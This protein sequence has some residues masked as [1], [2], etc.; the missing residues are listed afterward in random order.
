MRRAGLRGPAAESQPMTMQL[1]EA[2]R[3][4]RL[5]LP[6]LLMTASAA[7]WATTA[8]RPESGAH[9]VDEHGRTVVTSAARFEAVLA[10]GLPRVVSLPTADG[11]SGRFTIR[12]APVMEAE[13]AAR[14]PRIRTYRGAG[15]DDPTSL[16]RLDLT[17]LGFH[18]MVL[19]PSGTVL[20]DP[21]EARPLDAGRISLPGRVRA[22]S[23]LRCATP[24]RE[25]D[26][27]AR[28]VVVP[29]SRAVT[30]DLLRTYRIAIAATGEYTAFH[31][32]TVETGLAA[33]ITVLNRIAGI[34]ER[35]ASV[36]LILA[37][38]NDQIIY[39]DA[40]A[41]PYTNAD[42]R[43]MTVENQENL[44][45]VI[46]SGNYDIGHVFGT[47]PQGRGEGRVCEEGRKGRGV[48]G[49]PRPTAE[50]F[51]IQLVVHEIG[52]Q[53]DA[54]HTF[55]G[56]TR[57]CAGRRWGP[58]AWEPGS[59]STIMSYAGICGRENVAKLGDDY[60]HTGSVDEMLAWVS[61]GVG[62]GCG[63]ASAGDNSPP[64]ADAGKR[65]KI[66]VETP[67]ELSGS[68]GDPDGDALTFVWEQFD[69]GPPSPPMADDGLRPLFRS[70]PPAA[71]ATRIIPRT[72]DLLRRRSTVKEILPTT[73]RKL[74]FRLTV[75]DG[76]GGVAYDTVKL[77]VEDEAGPFRL[78]V[79]RARDAWRIGGEESVEWAVAETDRK[80]I[81]CRRVDLWLSSDG[82]KTFPILLLEGTPNDGFEMVAVPD[83]PTARA[84]VKV[85]CSTNIFF[86][87]SDGDFR[88]R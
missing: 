19:S 48:S 13:L 59:G 50:F 8:E 76:R 54:S 22:S 31:G 82:G 88:L 4:L 41:D 24:G 85:S 47:Y 16:A 79:P 52:H 9:P 2:T 60:F 37:N 75:R 36:R 55:N 80:P 33:V 86:A 28:S 70:Y 63:E 11:G 84:R 23:P 6:F 39:T 83:E 26:A 74:T 3:A 32:G 81:R 69:L 15:I 72:R 29:A 53:F 71:E 44:D 43:R 14:F 12:E 62:A 45:R 66:P 5:A 73:K 78:L 58:S 56:T 38:D 35:D 27:A 42:P 34:F 25:H 18:A 64:T 51:A 87:I 1:P 40:E 10:R 20:V 49:L 68:A 61:E 21:D 65:Y 7:A 17:P 67:F 77:R 57:S 30:G 46:G